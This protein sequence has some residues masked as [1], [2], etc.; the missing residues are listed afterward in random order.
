[1][2]STEGLR[3]LSDL[4][5]GKD[6]FHSTGFDV[7]GRYVVYVKYMNHETLHDIPDFMDGRQ[8][9]VHFSGSLTATS[10]QF[11]NQPQA[12]GASLKAHVPSYPELELEGAARRADADGTMEPT[13]DE[14]DDVIGVEEEE[15]S[16]LHL[17]KELDRLEKQCGSYTLQDIFYEI[18][19]GKN[20]VTNMSARY[21]EVRKGLEKLYSQYGF[22][23]IYEEL[24]G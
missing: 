12:P 21:P 23:V 7:Y 11:V 8:V 1:M 14:V 24:D 15:K 6:W 4:Y 16:V 22:D 3:M 10:A 2:D 17:Q 20:A 13:V 18:Q 9:L 19:D 5:K